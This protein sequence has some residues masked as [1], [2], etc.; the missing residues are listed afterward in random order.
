MSLDEFSSADVGFMHATFDSATGCNLPL[1]RG[2][3]N[4]EH[5]AGF[6]V[7]ATY[8]QERGVYPVDGPRDRRRLDLY[9]H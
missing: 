7:P 2:G 9:S 5:G 1:W 6:G 8:L 3:V 4:G